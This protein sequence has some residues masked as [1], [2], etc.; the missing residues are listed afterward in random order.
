MFEICCCRF[1][2][3]SV[4]VYWVRIYS[5]CNVGI[6]VRFTD[7]Y[8]HQEVSCIWIMPQSY[9]TFLTD[10]KKIE[11]NVH[12]W[13]VLTSIIHTKCIDH[14][15]GCHCVQLGP[16]LHGHPVRFARKKGAK[17]LQFCGF[18]QRCSRNSAR[19]RSTVGTWKLDSFRPIFTLSHF[20]CVRRWHGWPGDRAIFGDDI[21]SPF[22]K[23]FVW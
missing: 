19:W 4:R 23:W 21:C 22:I 2:I 8:R 7:L 17:Q 14:S 15:S 16:L 9:H 1:A 10:L 12:M 6:H 13:Y 5:T 20:G 3:G 18:F 11:G